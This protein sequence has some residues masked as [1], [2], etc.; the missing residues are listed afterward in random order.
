M[1]RTEPIVNSTRNTIDRVSESVHVQNASQGPSVLRLV[2]QTQQ[3]YSDGKF[4]EAVREDDEY[5]VEIQPCKQRK[6]PLRVV[7]KYLDVLSETNP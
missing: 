3:E 6:H 7:L 1:A 4:D 2:R 5:R